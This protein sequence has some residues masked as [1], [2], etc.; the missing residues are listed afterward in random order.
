MSAVVLFAAGDAIPEDSSAVYRTTLLQPDDS[1]VLTGQVDDIR[2]TLRDIRSK[3]IVNSRNS[4]S[5]LNRNGG[6]LTDGQFEMLFDPADMPAIGGRELQHRKLTI[7][8]YLS[9]GGR[10]TR[11]AMFWVQS[12]QDIS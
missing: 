7:D 6:T 9:G 12:L 11:E 10:A 2:L 3:Q 4:V 8:F 5:V 1:P